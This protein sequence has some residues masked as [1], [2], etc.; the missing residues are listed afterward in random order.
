MY[1]VEDHSMIERKNKMNNITIVVPEE[2]E[3]QVRIKYVR[4]KG[5]ISKTVCRVKKR[6]PETEKEDQGAKNV[7][8]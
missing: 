1:K 2:L 4:H 6:L 8:R 3:C 7:I 5:D